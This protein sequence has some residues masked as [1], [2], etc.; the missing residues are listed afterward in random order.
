[1]YLR[2]SI[3]TVKITRN[4]SKSNILYEVEL[5]SLDFTPSDECQAVKSVSLKDLD[6]MKVFGTVTKLAE[7]FDAENHT[8]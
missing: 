6:E 2:C 8:R 7:L 3:A 5:D 4:P 1:M